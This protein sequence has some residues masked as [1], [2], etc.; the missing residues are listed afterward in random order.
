MIAW[1][2]DRRCSFT[3]GYWAGVSEASHRC[4]ALQAQEDCLICKHTS[5]LLAPFPQR[6]REFDALYAVWASKVT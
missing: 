6:S 1:P 4:I 5:H 2:C 3:T